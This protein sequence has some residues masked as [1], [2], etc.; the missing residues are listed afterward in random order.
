[1]CAFLTSVSE[2]YEGEGR[3]SMFSNIFHGVTEVLSRELRKSAR[4]LALTVFMFSL[5]HKP[6]DKS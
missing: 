3:K 2:K 4:I 1:M 6:G 5:V